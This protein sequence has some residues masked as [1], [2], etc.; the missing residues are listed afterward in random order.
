ML[1]Q[2]TVCLA[3]DKTIFLADKQSRFGE[4]LMEAED[5]PPGS[6]RQGVCLQIMQQGYESETILNS[7]G[8]P[9]CPTQTTLATAQDPRIHSAASLQRTCYIKES[10]S[11]K[12]N[13]LITQMIIKYILGQLSFQKQKQSDE[14]NKKCKQRKS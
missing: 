1:W 3:I 4:N 2:D 5:V 13:N 12:I 8:M 6:G 11:Q 10:L 9:A 7:Y 14:Q